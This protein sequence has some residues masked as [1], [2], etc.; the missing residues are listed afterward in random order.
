MMSILYL[1]VIYAVCTVVTSSMLI[2]TSSKLIT[3]Y[4]L[5]EATENLDKISTSGNISVVG[6]VDYIL[7]INHGNMNVTKIVM[8]SPTEQTC[9]AYGNKDCHNYVRVVEKWGSN[10]FFLCGTNA[11]SEKCWTLDAQTH[12]LTVSPLTN[13]RQWLPTGRTELLATLM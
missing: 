5:P 10:N 9:L 12:Q 6:G 2:T 11:R 1:V 7:I 8:K 4:T 13:I 3:S